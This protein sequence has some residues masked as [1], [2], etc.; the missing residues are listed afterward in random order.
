MVDDLIA[1]LK[2][3]GQLITDYILRY[4]VIE[5]IAPD[6]LRE[7]VTYYVRKGGKRLRPAILLWATEIVGGN[8]AVAI[9]AAAAIELSHTWTLVHDDIIDNDNLRRGGPSMHA[10]YRE[11]WCDRVAP[12]ELEAWSRNLAMLVG[13]IQQAVATSMVNSLS[14]AVSS[15]VRQWL[16]DHLTT[17]WLP[18]VLQGEML[19]VEYSIKPLDQIKEADILNM[20]DRKTASTLAWCAMAGAMIGL[21]R[22]EPNHPT[23]KLLIEIFR[24]AGLAFQL[25]D[26]ILGIIGNESELGKPI[27]SDIREG[28][29]TVI[30]VYAYRRA[31]QAQ[32]AILREIIGKTDASA[33]EIEQVRTMLIDLGGIAYARKLAEDYTSRA[34]QALR[35]LPE[36]PT[37]QKLQALVN[38]MTQRNY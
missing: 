34:E 10:Y 30:V 5:R 7:G 18:E 20:L 19:D 23:I 17:D 1:E 25:W 24:Q 11:T 28:K 27:G 35:E 15:E 26:D 2:T 8:A 21:N 9:P 6:Y 29:R 16:V 37:R 38:F 3:T 13:D 31:N 12:S 33:T 36:S 14:A 22:I 4:P 32:Q